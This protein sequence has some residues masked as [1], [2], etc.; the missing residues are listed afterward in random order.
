MS[1]TGIKPFREMNPKPIGFAFLAS[2]VVLL[3][4][5]F[6]INRLPFTGGTG[7][8]AA[9]PHAQG[10]HKGD[11]VMIGGVVV[12]K[13][14][15]VSLEGTHV[16]VGGGL[17]EL[18]PNADQQRHPRRGGPADDEARRAAL[19]GEKPGD[20]QQEDLGAAVP[21]DRLL[22]ERLDPRREVE[23]DQRAAGEERDQRERGESSHG[24][25]I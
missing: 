14:T 19:V 17:R 4:L 24:M 3:L 11:R 12:G 5:A 2:I 23:R 22:L 1:L 7:Y 20:V 16:R 15:S 6:N 9:L 10:L 8:S 21:L 13:V 25:S 18:L